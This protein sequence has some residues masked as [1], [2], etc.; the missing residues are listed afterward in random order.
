MD[1][2]KTCY[3]ME[4]SFLF[5]RRYLMGLRARALS[6]VLAFSMM[7]SILP[8][9]RAFAADNASSTPI[10]M[11]DVMS[12]GHDGD[13]AKYGYPIGSGMDHKTNASGTG[14]HYDGS[15]ETL[16]LEAGYTF[17]NHSTLNYYTSCKVINDAKVDGWNLWYGNVV[18]NGTIT[19]SRIHP[20]LTTNNATGVISTCRIGERAYNYA[21]ENNGK[22]DHCDFIGDGTV[23]GDHF[24]ES[25]T[26][27][28]VTLTGSGTIDHCVFKSKTDYPGNNTITNSAFLNNKQ[29]F[30]GMRTIKMEDGETNTKL[31]A[32]L[33]D[34]N[35]GYGVSGLDTIGFVGSPSLYVAG[36]S[37]YGGS[38]QLAS[39]NGKA[40]G[41]DDIP[42][43]TTAQTQ[44]PPASVLHAT[45]NGFAL[46]PDGTSGIILSQVVAPAPNPSPDGKLVLDETGVPV[47]TSGE[48]WS[49]EPRTLYDYQGARLALVIKQN[50]SI[51]LAGN[52][53]VSVPVYLENDAALEGGIYTDA[54]YLNSTSTLKNATLFRGIGGHKTTTNGMVW[55]SYPDGAVFKFTY[56]DDSI[57]DNI[58]GNGGVHLPIGT[59]VEMTVPVSAEEG[60]A[61]WVPMESVPVSDY[62]SVYKR[63]AAIPG[64]SDA[65]LASSTLVF[66]ATE[67]L[68]DLRFQLDHTITIANDCVTVSNADGKA[69]T[70]AA[71]WEKV[72]LTPT[73][74]AISVEEFFQNLS[75]TGSVSIM[76]D[77]EGN[78]YFTMPDS[79]V[80]IQTSSST[81]PS[82]PAGPG[83]ESDGAGVA[84]AVVAVTAI[85]AVSYAVVTRVWLE[86][87]LPEGSSIPTSRQQLADLLWIAAGRPEPVS[88]VLYPDI[89]AAEVDHQK[90]ALWCVEQGLLKDNGEVFRPND[91]TFRPQVIKAWNQL[92]DALNAAQ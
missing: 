68:D 72:Y 47:Y 90:A 92:Q 30:D 22:I 87:I 79:A 15:T 38:R 63:I 74:T 55:F 5:L 91:H 50:A 86:S 6:L 89:S 29:N 28:T 39:V 34:C 61:G 40:I 76:N 7:L 65:D 19:N 44:D 31:F 21:V 1:L 58:K 36:E 46:T 48:G 54:V 2:Y 88:K 78:Y 51:P 33:Y 17:V 32:I 52:Q 41:A 49:Y 83:G 85:G 23:A 24:H 11:S 10:E 45:S 42:G 35:S 8:L 82:E 75:I 14:W 13:N 69:I 73:D 9:P 53:L 16:Y 81:D 70:A 66:T 84:G 27:N 37:S 25:S 80:T 60:F 77:T 18:N 64:Q 67:K 4:E 71:Q 62:S 12:L 26:A 59:K 56:P 57:A 3:C 43:V 20:D